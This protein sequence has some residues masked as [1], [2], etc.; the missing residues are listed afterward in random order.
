MSRTPEDSHGTAEEAVQ[1][2]GNAH[3]AMSPREHR[4]RYRQRQLGHRP[5]DQ[6]HAEQL[7]VV[8]RRD[9]T[10]PKRR[11]EARD[12][13]RASEQ[14]RPRASH[15]RPRARIAS[16]SAVERAGGSQRAGV[17]QFLEKDVA[18][19]KRIDLRR[20]RQSCEA[21]VE[22]Y[23]VRE[24]NRHPSNSVLPTPE[25]GR[26][27]C[28]EGGG[29]GPALTTASLG[30]WLRRLSTHVS[31]PQGFPYGNIRKII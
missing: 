27:H 2:G 26:R 31:V 6:R 18:R 21:S 16:P 23:A 14:S 25:R 9:S 3:D 12:A 8:G 20:R 29:S 4:V 19:R 13:R 17:H 22:S 11:T 5:E 1:H 28:R 24:R 15:D 30:D 7:S 10:D